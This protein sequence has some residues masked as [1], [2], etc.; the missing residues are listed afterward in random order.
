MEEKTMIANMWETPDGTVL[1]SRYTHDSVNYIDKNGIRYMVDGGNDYC[2]LSDSKEHP[3]KNR[4]VFND[5]PWD[6]QRKFILRGTFDQDGNRVWVPLYKLSNGHIDSLVADANI[7]ESTKI[8]YLT[9]QAYRKEHKIN[10]HTHD[11]AFEG[12]QPISSPNPYVCPHCGSKN[13]HCHAGMM[14]D[15]YEC[16]DCHFDWR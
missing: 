2:H 3:M 10:I 5:E 9:E 8:N 12:V 11:Y 15:R 7:P 6:I 1:W 13:V 4:C 16:E 14:V